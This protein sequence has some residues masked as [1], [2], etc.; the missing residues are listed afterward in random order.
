MN[1]NVTFGNNLET[2]MTAYLYFIM[3]Y[4]SYK[5]IKICV[6]VNFSTQFI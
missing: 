6:K 1:V 5:I 3:S 2:G 4:F